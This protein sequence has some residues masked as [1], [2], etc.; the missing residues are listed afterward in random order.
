M[1]NK[2]ALAMD[3]L[4]DEILDYRKKTG[5]TQVELAQRV[6]VNH[7]TVSSIER[8]EKLFLRLGTIGKF[9]RFFNLDDDEL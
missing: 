7:K 3:K 5:C 1:A 8:G 2:R 9:E 4:R 6:G